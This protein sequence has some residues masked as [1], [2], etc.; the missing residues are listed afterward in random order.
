MPENIWS[1][2]A[3]KLAGGWKCISYELFNGTGPD[4]KLVAK[5]HGDKPL[6]RVLLSSNGYLSALMAQPDRMSQPLPSG[7]AWQEAPDAEVAHVARGSSM[8]CGYLELFECEV[9]EGEKGEMRWQTR[10]EVC[11]DP[12]RMGGLEE[13][14]VKYFEEGG[15]AFMELQPVNEMVMEVSRCTPSEHESV[16]TVPAGWNKSA[17]CAEVGEVRVVVV[18][19][20]AGLAWCRLSYVLVAM[21]AGGGMLNDSRSER[22]WCLCCHQGDLGMKEGRKKWKDS[23]SRQPLRLSLCYTWHSLHRPKTMQQ[24]V[25]TTLHFIVSL[26]GRYPHLRT[27]LSSAT[28]QRPRAAR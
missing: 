25:Y 26:H 9:G 28:A 24:I 20:S 8:Y 10:V 15:K 14:K 5:P 21:Q 6:G 27:N 19:A 11:S 22:V 1:Q 4:K 16:L 17:R 2:H 3:S 18:V 23:A 7:K 12:N 13:R